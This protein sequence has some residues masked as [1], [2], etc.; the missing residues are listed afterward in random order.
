M[1]FLRWT[2]QVRTVPERIME[3]SLLFLPPEVFGATIQRFGFDAKRYA[4]YGASIAMLAVLA[5]LG[6]WALQRRWSAGWIVALAL[7]LWLFTMTVLMPLTD[8]GFFAIDL[9]DG[10]KT[11]VAAHFAVALTYAAA[12]VAMQ[13]RFGLLGGLT[14]KGSPPV[15][16]RRTPSAAEPLTRRAALALAGSAVM[17]YGATLLLNALGP[18]RRYPAARAID[19]QVPLPSGGLDPP[20]PH[21]Y[22]VLT[23]AP[24]TRQLIRDKDG[25]VLTAGRQRGELATQMTTNNDFYVVTKNAVADPALATDQWRLVVDGEVEQHIEFSYDT[26]RRLPGVEL[27]KTLECISNFVTKCELAPFGCDLISTARW[28]GVRVAD[29]LGVAGLKPGVVSLATICADEFITALPIEAALDPD[30]LL[31][32]EMNGETLPREHGYPLRLLI[33][34]RYGMKNAK[35]VVALRPLRR[36]FA[37]WYGQRNWSREGIVRTMTRIDVPAAGAVLPPGEQDVAGIA[38]AGDRGISKVEFSTDGGATW[39]VAAFLEPAPGRDAWVRWR[40]RFTLQP[41][42]SI[43]ITARATDGT[44]ELQIEPFTLPEP[45]GGTGWHTTDIRARLF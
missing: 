33:P 13:V 31:V 28:K 27:T 41:G 35:W 5:A 19:P 42:A 24:G 8:A 23:P 29:V 25:A 32:Y 4:L 7:G 26:I 22:P 44:G 21:P 45:D 9:V 11:A 10:T 37:D 15:S 20:E 16:Q 38:Y 30:T 39:L 14:W 12:L 1:A 43:T 2:L 3:G 34:G 40:G 6:A 18:S 17:A 36:Q